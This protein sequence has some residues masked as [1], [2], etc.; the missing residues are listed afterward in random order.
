MPY[1]HNCAN[2]KNS[3]RDE[4]F[5]QLECKCPESDFYGDLVDTGFCCGE[6]VW[7]AAT[8]R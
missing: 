1:M 4:Q 8:P 6:W 2:C 7:K 5:E 3:E